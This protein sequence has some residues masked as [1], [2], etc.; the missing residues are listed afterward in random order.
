VRLS[1]DVLPAIFAEVMPLGE[2]EGEANCAFV[3]DT[4]QCRLLFRYW[5]LFLRAAA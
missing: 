5:K 3:R 1:W 4:E 2:T